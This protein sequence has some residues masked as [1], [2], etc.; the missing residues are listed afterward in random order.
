[1]KIEI[2]KQQKFQILIKTYLKKL[3]FLYKSFFNNNFLIDI[4][5]KKEENL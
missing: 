2:I 1:M 4:T 5:N 3:N